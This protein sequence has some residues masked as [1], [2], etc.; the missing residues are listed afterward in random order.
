MDDDKVIEAHPFGPYIVLD[1]YSTYG[2]ADSG[3]I[4][5]YVSEE[6]QAELESTNDFSSV[7]EEN[8][9]YVS[10]SDLLTIY[11]EAK[12]LGIPLTGLDPVE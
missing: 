6:G 11:L 8:I 12:A 2:P 7:S 9:I 3:A 5:C 1:D 4:V 10:V